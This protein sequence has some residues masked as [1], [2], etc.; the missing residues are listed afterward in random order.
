[1]NPI[2][3]LSLCFRFLIDSVPIENR[4]DNSALSSTPI[5]IK[6]HRRTSSSSNEAYCIRKHFSK[7]WSFLLRT[8]YSFRQ[9]SS[10]RCWLWVWA[11]IASAKGEA[12]A[13]VSSCSLSTCLVISLV[14]VNWLAIASLSFCNR[15]FSSLSRS[16]SSAIRSIASCEFSRL[17]WWRFLCHFH[18]KPYTHPLKTSK[19]LTQHTSIHRCPRS[20]W[21]CS[22]W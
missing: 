3:S 16:F 21:F 11:R 4:H 14:V 1:M 12:T 7:A 18:N 15:R 6:Q 19:A 20:A 2:R 22:L 13:S 10:E 9:S 5:R 8:A 17:V